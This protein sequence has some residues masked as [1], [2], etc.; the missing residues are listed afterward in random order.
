MN[1]DNLVKVSKHQK[2]RGM[3]C[4]SKP[5]NFICEGCQHG[6]HTKASFPSKEYFASKPLQ[7]VHTDLCGPTRTML[8]NVEKYFMLFIDDYTRMTWVT[9]LKHKLEAFNKFKIFRKM[10]ENESDMKIKFVQLDKRGEFTSDEFF[11]Y[12]EKTWHQKTIC[13]I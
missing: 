3:P 13:S 4:I 9:F 12:C 1:F 7:L 8:L 10:V 2:V 6:K 11:D 5:E